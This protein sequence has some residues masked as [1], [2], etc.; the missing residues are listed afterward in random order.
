MSLSFSET[1]AI[2]ASDFLSSELEVVFL[3]FFTTFSLSFTSC[4]HSLYVP[5]IQPTSLIYP[6]TTG[7]EIFGFGLQGGGEGAL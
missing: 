2:V 3:F 5:K 1:V 6:P 4:L 7:S